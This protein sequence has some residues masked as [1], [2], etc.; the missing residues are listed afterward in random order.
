MSAVDKL[1]SSWYFAIKKQEIP[2]DSSY[3]VTINGCNVMKN[4][5]K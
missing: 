2:S 4:P 3:Q 1:P 5:S